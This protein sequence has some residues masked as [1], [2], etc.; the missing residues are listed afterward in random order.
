MGTCSFPIPTARAFFPA[1]H[2]ERV[3][4]A[5]RFSHIRAKRYIA[6]IGPGPKPAL[7]FVAMNQLNDTIWWQGGARS[8]KS[9][10]RSRLKS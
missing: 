7:R 8:L 4:D 1:Q 2:N 5:S 6:C 9:T 3:S 10:I